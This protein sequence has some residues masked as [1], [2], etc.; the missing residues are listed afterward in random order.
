MFRLE[1][2]RRNSSSPPTG[3][4][5]NI[6]NRFDAYY[7]LGKVFCYGCEFITF[8][9]YN[10]FTNIDSIFPTQNGM[11]ILPYYLSD[12]DMKEDE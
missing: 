9:T 8:T 4:I 10:M 1:E 3:L 6:T 12:N 7:L 11:H 5:A 2:L